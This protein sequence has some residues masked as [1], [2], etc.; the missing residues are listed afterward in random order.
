MKFEDLSQT[1]SS[2]C[3]LLSEEGKQEEV[4]TLL[5]FLTLVNLNLALSL[6]QTEGSA[7]F[8]SSGGTDK[9]QSMDKGALTS[10]LGSLLEGQ[11]TG[12]LIGSL[13]QNPQMLSKLA[14]LLGN[15]TAKSNTKPEEKKISHQEVKTK[16]IQG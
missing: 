14:S 3:E 16:S 13:A 5:A 6:I 4:N 12:D 10:A 9:K 11:D 7:P 1:V 8:M 2:F 15:K